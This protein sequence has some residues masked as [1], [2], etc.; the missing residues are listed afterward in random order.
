MECPHCKKE[1]KVNPVVFMNAD[2]YSRTNLIVTQCC[3]KPV[4]LTPV[5]TYSVSQYKGERTE[6]DWG[7]DIK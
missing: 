3:G 2:I 4:T 7:N 6:D 5:R 1:L